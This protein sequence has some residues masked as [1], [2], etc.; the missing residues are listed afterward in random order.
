MCLLIWSICDHILLSFRTKITNKLAIKNSYIFSFNNKSRIPFLWRPILRFSDSNY[1]PVD[2]FFGYFMI[3]NIHNIY[4]QNWH[5]HLFICSLL[6][7]TNQKVWHT[8]LLMYYL[9]SYHCHNKHSQLFLMNFYEM[10]C[11]HWYCLKLLFFH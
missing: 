11:L 8:L 10:N 4:R 2:T 3:I 9:N 1:I 6:H 7:F 5:H